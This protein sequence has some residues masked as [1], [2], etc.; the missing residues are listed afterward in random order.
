MRRCDVSKHALDVA[1]AEVEDATATEGRGDLAR[2]EGAVA[3]GG[4][5]L[6]GGVD[7]DLEPTG[8]PFSEGQ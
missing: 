1:G 4:A 7:I 8:Q 6:E 3:L 2:D 5:G